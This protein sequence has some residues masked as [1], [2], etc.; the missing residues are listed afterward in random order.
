MA[1]V[2][3]T[4]STTAKATTNNTEYPEELQ[5]ILEDLLGSEHVYFQPPGDKKLDYP[6]IVYQLDGVK[7]DYADN[8]PY[9]NHKRYLITYISQ[10]PDMYIPDKIAQMKTASFNRFFVQDN[11]NHWAYRVYFTSIPNNLNKED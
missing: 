10:R 3:K 6:C 9:N 7:T 8:Y 4:I 2:K 11:L 5:A 1:V